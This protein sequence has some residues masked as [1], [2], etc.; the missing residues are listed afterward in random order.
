M[1]DNDDNLSKDRQFIKTKAHGLTAHG[2]S[3][4]IIG[5]C[6]V[7]KQKHM[8]CQNMSLVN[9]IFQNKSTRPIR[10][11]DWSKQKIINISIQKH[12]SDVSI[13]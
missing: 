11:H 2:L 4:H 8:D 3:T 10:M 7:S 5:Q 12:M 6:K 9:A 1:I 13:N